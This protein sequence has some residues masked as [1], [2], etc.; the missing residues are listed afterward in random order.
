MHPLGNVCD[1]LC[2]KEAFPDMGV[3]TKYDQTEPIYLP[4]SAV[5]YIYLHSVYILYY[6]GERTEPC[7]TP[8]CISLGTDISPSTETFNFLWEKNS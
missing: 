2:Q 8:A 1:P 7:G 4:Q 6:V 5:T 3:L